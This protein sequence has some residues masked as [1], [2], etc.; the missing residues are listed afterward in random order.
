M[1]SGMNIN[2]HAYEE[3]TCTECGHNVFVPGVVFK[4][5]PGILVGQSDRKT[6]PFP[7]K[8]AC[9]AKCG[10][11]S[12]KDKEDLEKE[13]EMAKKAAAAPKSGLII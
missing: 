2:P 3:L 6:V 8:V 10:A 13:A 7:I 1:E 9:C 5:I 12:K 11:L 4:Q